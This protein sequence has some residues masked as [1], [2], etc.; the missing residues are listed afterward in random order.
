MQRTFLKIFAVVI[1]LSLAAQ[2]QSLADIARQCKE[3]Q[4]AQQSSGVKPKVITNQ[5]LGE[6]PEGRPDLRVERRTTAS[7]AGAPAFDR[8]P[9]E[10]NQRPDN[11]VG[12]RQGSG[13]R[14]GPRPEAWSEQRSAL[15]RPETQGG[16]EQWKE[17]VLEQENRVASLQARID[18]MHAAARSGGTSAQG[19]YNRYQARQMERAAEMQQQ[20]EE[21][22]RKL[23]AMQEAAR[24]QGMHTQVYDP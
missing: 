17:R 15:Q 18:Q 16:G 5:D 14:Q 12:P 24:R 7:A 9:G 6:G 22:K 4:G 13:Q 8:S 21:Q 19:P 3:K 1:L 2:G 11:P 10:M 23:D 20:L